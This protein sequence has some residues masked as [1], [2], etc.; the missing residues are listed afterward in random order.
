MNKRDYD[1]VVVGTGP[2]G[3]AA[4]I[5]LQRKGLSV[6][7]IEGRDTVGG[8]MR[9]EELTL[10]GFVHD[11]CSAIHPLAISSIFFRGVPLSDFGLEF[12]KPTLAAAHPLD[13]GD[14]GILSSSIDATAASLGVD[15][16]KYKQFIT[17]LV[18]DWPLTSTAVLAPLHFPSPF[19]VL[20]MMRFG[21]KGLPSITRL[22]SRF[23]APQTRGLLAGI[24]A[25]IMQPLS[26]MA[27]S[28]ISLVLTI[29]GHTTGWPLPRGGS[30][31]IA[32][33]LAS[34]FKS[35]GGEIETGFFVKSLKQLPSSHAVLLD[36]TPRQLLQIAGY[37]LSDFYRW[38]LRRYRY[39][40]GVFKMDWA[41]DGPIP[42]RN[43]PCRHAGT[44]HLGNTFEEIRES[45]LLASK[46]GYPSRPFVIMAQQSL[47][48][49]RRAPPGKHTGWAYCHVPGGSPRS[50]ADEIEGQVER[51]APG[52][53]ERILARHMFNAEQMEE[54]DPNYVGGDINGGSQDIAQLFTRP[55]IRLSP[56]RTS[57]KGIYI[58]SSSTP[59]GGGVHGLCGYYA[60]SRALR[61]VFSSRL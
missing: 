51:F 23:E 31:S 21:V 36:V 12:I 41:L 20:P 15:A 30:R 9:S 33:A 10:P 13:N 5:T 27:T 3:F 37:R 22:V 16:E 57:T 19:Q 54:Y 53:R 18:T 26:N 35:L 39:G 47:F 60:A 42:F 11:V 49:D 32:T 44:V 59:P 56:Y 7:M 4:A 52:F 58:C 17:P 6:L 24:G 28:A 1:A 48:D 61:D 38:Q 34:Y 50:M 2:N 29:L 8:G 46:G 45:E 40:M 55:T 14:T 43:E 25:H